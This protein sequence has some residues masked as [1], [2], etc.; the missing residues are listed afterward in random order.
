MFGKQTLRRFIL[1]TSVPPLLNLYRGYYSF[2]TML[3]L[4]LFRTFPEVKAVYLRRGGGSGKIFPLIS[5]L[6]FAVFVEEL[7]EQRRR[8][9]VRRYKELGRRTTVLDH[10]LE[11]Y[12]VRTF[13]NLYQ[14]SRRQYRFMEGRATWK[15]LYGEPFMQTLPA[16]SL[17][18][19]QPGFYRELKIWWTVFVWRQVQKGRYYD[20]PTSRNSLC[21]KATAEILKMELGL[22]HGRLIYSKDEALAQ[23]TP[24][25]DATEA[26][27]VANVRK[28]GRRHYRGGSAAL[29]GETLH[30]LMER[31]DRV[32]ARFS[33]HPLGRAPDRAG[34]DAPAVVTEPAAGVSGEGGA[35]RARADRIVAHVRASWGDTY[36]G[37]ALVTGFYFEM[38]ERA[39]VL[40]VDPARPPSIEQLRALYERHL[41]NGARTNAPPTDTGGEE[42]EETALRLYV[43]LRRVALQIDV[44]YYARGW[45]SVLLPESNPDVFTLLAHPESWIDGAPDA[46]S[47]P[48]RAQP[49]APGY[50][51]TALAGNFV[52]EE[53]DESREQL[54]GATPAQ[55]GNGAIRAAAWSLLRYEVMR[56]GTR[57]GT[58]LV[59]LTKSALL[60][61]ASQ[62]GLGPVVTILM[63][64]RDAD[65]ALFRRAIASVL[66]QTDAAWRLI[67]I[68]DGSEDAGTRA[69]LDA[70][71]DTRDPRIRVAPS[72]ARM[73]TGALNTGMRLADTPFVCMFHCDDLLALHALSVL[74][75]EIENSPAVDYFHSSRVHI[76]EH[77]APL[78]EPYE[79][80][81]SFTLD[82]FKA[83]GPVKHLHCWRVGKAIEAGGMDETLGPHG[84]DD[85]D[86]PWTMMEAGARFQAIRECLYYYRDR[87]A[88]KRLTTHVPLDTQ[89]GELVKIFRKH[90]MTEQEIEDQ[91]RIRRAGYLQQALY[92]TDADVPPGGTGTS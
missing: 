29:A 6:D 13:A 86:F 51:W 71:R 64:C 89:V 36:R 44:D 70:L 40:A 69:E 53:R 82:D 76:D 25:L 34:L 47:E 17:E 60:R 61:A 66:S 39:L 52:D 7:G 46:S 26:A 23:S 56:A 42:R 84:A 65:P 18:Q 24:F 38:G 16:L 33:D 32:A 90:G 54:R 20:E 59:P 73:V 81:E 77:D 3:A 78:D 15:L 10:F 88:Q 28:I 35:L 14:R 55:A 11:L 27:H 85:Y 22:F 92:K 1:A 4:R 83:H 49:N 50:P 21:F 5:D 57:A 37:A 79:A 75:R 45:Q 58:A 31:F 48:G 67:V 9:L 72:E 19:M 80:R 74:R 68:D 43:L 63:P 8:E 30:F 2:V 91:I 12:D 41:A 62:C 87:G